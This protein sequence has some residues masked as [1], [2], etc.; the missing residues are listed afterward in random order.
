[1]SSVVFQLDT[2][3]TMSLVFAYISS[4]AVDLFM[5]LGYIGQTRL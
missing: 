1:M 4:A 5:D 2:F 3:I